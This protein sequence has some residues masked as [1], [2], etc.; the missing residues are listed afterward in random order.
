MG[1]GGGGRGGL[2]GCIKMRLNTIITCTA[3][4]SSLR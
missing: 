3:P 2:C 4:Y 1:G